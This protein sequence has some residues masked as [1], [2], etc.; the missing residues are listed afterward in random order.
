[1]AWFETEGGTMTVW[2]A[3]EHHRFEAA[4]KPFVYLVPSAAIFAL[5]EA[6]DA[7]L[8]VGSSGTHSSRGAAG[9]VAR[10]R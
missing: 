5:D 2:G 9:D 6:A 1:M 10:G 4:G 3:R 7:V 8:R